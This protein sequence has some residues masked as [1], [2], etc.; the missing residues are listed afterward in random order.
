MNDL[1]SASGR[2]PAPTLA[3]GPAP[4]IQ[5]WYVSYA[6]LGLVVAGVGPIVLPLLAARS[7]G[8]SAPGLVM[9]AF[10]L[11]MV[12][13]PLW[14][15]LADRSGL[16]RLLYVAGLLVVAAGIAL[17]S[18]RSGVGWFAVMALVVGV[19]ASA[20]ATVANLFVTELHPRESWGT[21]FGWLQTFYGGGQVFG[22]L[23][24]G[25][26]GATRAPLT[27]AA[28]ALAAVLAAAMFR[29]VPAGVRSSTP[30]SGHQLT[31][32]GGAVLGTLMAHVHL[33]HLVRALR[34][35]PE[36]VRAG[37]S[38]YLIFLLGWFLANAGSAALFS[39]YPL[40]MGQ[41][42]GL[43]TGAAS[44]VFAG[45]A[46]LGL[47]LYGPAGA[48]AKRLGAGRVYGVGLLVRVAAF[49]FLILVAWLQPATRG[50]LG[51]AGFTVVVLAWSLLAVAGSDLAADTSELPEG[52]AMGLY[53]ASGAVAAVVGSLLGGV[54]AVAVGYG[55]LLWLGGAL[56]LAAAALTPRTSTPRPGRQA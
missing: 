41:V 26:I 29:V 3:A 6:L 48:G 27:L 1:P 11:G 15:A 28:A 42:F 45:A 5:R 24:A 8:P 19:A 34:R 38:P 51:V 56:V 47:L 33:P 13:A 25:A 52:E 46:A 49:A 30:V 43:G 16:H 53:A 17:F 14:G 39:F 18:L 36:L 35:L 23:L 32:H 54:V 10:N 12:A 55:G 2:V 7:G 20:S 22:L 50:W 21:R 40:V 37:S 4:V 31:R 44:W 9:A